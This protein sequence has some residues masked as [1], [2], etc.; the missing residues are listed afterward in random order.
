VIA[1]ASEAIPTWSD[2]RAV[3]TREIGEIVVRGAG[4]SPRYYRRPD[5][6]RQARIQDGDVVWHRTGD[7]GYFD[8][9]GRLWFCG[10]ASQI[11]K[12][13]GKLY[14]PV[15][16]ENVVNAEPGVFRSGLVRVDAA[17][18]LV[19]CVEFRADFADDERGSKLERIAARTRAIDIPIARVLVHDQGFPVDARHNAKID[20]AALTAWASA[21]LGHA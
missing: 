12:H 14:Y 15:R 21:Q 17:E 11:L 20:Y 2:A 3:A 9:V 10:R 8:A 18:A 13:E 7:V 16:V 19:L 4:V 6:T 1:L 5:A